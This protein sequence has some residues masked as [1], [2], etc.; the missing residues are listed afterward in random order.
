MEFG[1][2]FAGWFALLLLVLPFALFITI[3]TA[4]VA[5][6][7]A[8]VGAIVATRAASVSLQRG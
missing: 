2:F 8:G 3:A 7:V 5:A 4:W 6:L 1:E